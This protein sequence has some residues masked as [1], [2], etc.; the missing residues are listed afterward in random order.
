MSTHV[1]TFDPVAQRP[2]PRRYAWSVFA[3]LFAL[4]VVDYVDRQVVVSMF[5][6]LKAQWS[7]SDSQLGALVSVVSVAVALGAV[8]L[9][10]VADRWGRV[11]SIF[12]MAV[13]WSLATLACAFTRDYASLVGARSVVGLGEAAYGT[14][15]A[16]LLATLFPPRM[17]GTVLG[18]FLAAAILGSVSGVML[19]GVLAERWGWQ[20]GFGVVS[21]PGL[22]LACLF[23]IIVRDYPTVDFS[24]GG[25]NAGASRLAGRAV[26]AELMRP[27]TAWITCLGA[28]FNLLVVSTMYAWLPSFFHRYYGLAPDRAGVK[29][30][31]VVL[32]GGVGALVL[33]VIA[34][35]ASSRLPSARLV[36]P[37]FAAV[38]TTVLLCIA[39]AA[40]PP[41]GA[42]FALILAG[43]CVMAGSVGPTDAVV[44]D[45]THPGLRATA[46][47]VLS[48]TRNLF[49]LAG[50]PLLAGALSDAYGLRFAMA[51]VPLFCLAAAALFVWAAR[52]Y[53]RDR[54]AAAEIAAEPAWSA[55]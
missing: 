45:V 44:I 26:V 52:S 10:L 51:V 15:G 9:S 31:L 18:A 1:A 46:V 37:A 5:P 20:A 50:G 11:K 2:A 49:G 32:L 53:P 3:I 38:A 17:R 25:R 41:G 54:R 8:P 14:A 42:Q 7:L 39:F 13:V 29:T 22:L 23:A 27:R 55:A 12:I 4:M 34:D 35:R 30:A 16:A 40:F 48:L 6:H 28:G 24:G 43:A 21:I 36:I 19:G 33:S 47:S